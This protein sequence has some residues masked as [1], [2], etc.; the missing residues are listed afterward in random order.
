MW[1]RQ[2]YP[3]A[4]R[5]LIILD[6]GGSFESQN[7]PGWSLFSEPRRY[8]TVG[9]K[10][11][12]VADLAIASGADALALF[13]D[14]DLYFPWHLSAAAEVLKVADVSAPSVVLADDGGRVKYSDAIGRHHGAW[15]FR[16]EI[17][18][19]AGGY[20][21]EINEGFDSQ[22][23][24]KM[25]AAGAITGDPVKVSPISY[26]YRWFSAGYS[27]GSAAGPSIYEA[28]A[29]SHKPERVRGRVVPALDSGAADYFA[30]LVSGD[31]RRLLF[32]HCDLRSA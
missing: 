3:E 10:F 17:Y 11:A 18:E 15:A 1:R 22:L 23:L 13:E 29:R 16:R 31:G 12:A 4:D 9:A 30:E 6:D 24:R 7:G 8:P 14:D 32:D 2:D 20:A 21:A 19:A 28:M 5:H 26:L 25:Q 27:N